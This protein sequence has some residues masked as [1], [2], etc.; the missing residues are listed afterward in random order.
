MP[1]PFPGMDP[2][3]EH[4]AIWRGVHASFITYGRDHLQAQLGESYYVA[5]DERVYIEEPDRSIYPDLA[6]MKQSRRPRGGAKASA[7]DR[8][9]VLL[10]EGTEVKEGFLEIRDVA[11]G[12]RVLCVIEVLSP[13]NKRRGPGRKLYVRKQAEVLASRAHLV[14]IDF[15]RGGMPTVALPRSLQGP[16]PYRVVV[17]RATA[18]NERELYAFDLRDRLPRV[19]VPVDAHHADLVLDLP[20]VMAEVYEKGVYARRLDYSQDPVPPFRAKDAS[21]ARE[22][23]AGRTSTS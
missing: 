8:P 23:I 2:Y 9:V 3:L 4:P 10:V 19:A 7:A 22:R 12:H 14:E 11:Q 18:R 17:S 5:I 6:V 16:D 20:A 13:T 15:L 1:S 21:W